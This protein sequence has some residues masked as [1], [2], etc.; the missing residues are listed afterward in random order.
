M[1]CGDKYEGNNDKLGIIIVL[2]IIILNLIIYK[3]M[4]WFKNIVNKI[5]VSIVFLK[6][7]KWI[8]DNLEL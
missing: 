7:I 1:K 4:F 2:M 3:Y 5:I 6:L 8:R